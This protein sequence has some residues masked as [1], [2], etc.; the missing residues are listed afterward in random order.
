MLCTCVFREDLKKEYSDLEV[1]LVVYMS[2]FE[3][4]NS[5]FK[6]IQEIEGQEICVSLAPNF[7]SPFPSRA[8][9]T[10]AS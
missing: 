10:Q 7:P 1:Y 5:Y 6:A 3:I 2:L 4:N 8:P 9:A